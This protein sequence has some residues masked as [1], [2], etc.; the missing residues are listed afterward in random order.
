MT[1]HRAYFL[2]VPIEKKAKM[3]GAACLLPISIGQIYHEGERLEALVD[4]INKNFSSC[5]VVLCDS[6]YRHTQQLTRVVNEEESYEASI[7]AGDKWIEENAIH[8]RRLSIHSSVRRWDRWLVGQPS[9]QKHL[10]A[11]EFFIET[12]SSFRQAIEDT[13]EDFLRRYRNSHEI[14]VDGDFAK[15][16]CIDYLKEEC[17]VVVQSWRKLGYSYLVYPQKIT[18]AFEQLFKYCVNI[19]DADML[20]WLTVRFKNKTENVVHCD[21][22]TATFEAISACSPS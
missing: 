19:Y 12:Q 17:A 8:L 5:E 21:F 11:V 9:F 15:K 18:P 7:K 3:L 2:N 4:L 1:H 13:A 22:R 14:I 6:L 16:I 20:D 10:R